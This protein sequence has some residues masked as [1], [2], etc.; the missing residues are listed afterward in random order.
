MP[1]KLHVNFHVKRI[2]VIRLS[3]FSNEL[4]F[5]RKIAMFI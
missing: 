2:F 4:A 5:H 3:S 1:E